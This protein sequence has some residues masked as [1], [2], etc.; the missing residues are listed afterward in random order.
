M[1]GQGAEGR[2]AETLQQVPCKAAVLMS[3]FQIQYE[4]CLCAAD[5]GEVT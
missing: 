3:A 1:Y 4:L 5:V 2:A